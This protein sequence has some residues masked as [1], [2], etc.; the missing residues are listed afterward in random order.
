MEKIIE[1]LIE[2]LT[3]QRALILS[4]LISLD[5]HALNYVIKEQNLK[6]LIFDIDCQISNHLTNLKSN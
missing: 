2:T 5:P 3:A 6:N 1:K 4:E